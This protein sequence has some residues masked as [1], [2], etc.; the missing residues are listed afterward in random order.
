M[1]LMLLYRSIN[2]VKERLMRENYSMF[3]CRLIN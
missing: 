2:I 1:L 3:N